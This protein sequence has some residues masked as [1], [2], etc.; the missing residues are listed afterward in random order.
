VHGIWDSARRIAP[1][2]RG[3]TARGF[4]HVKAMD[5]TPP[6]GN[7]RLEA[8]AEQVQR[9]VAEVRRESGHEQVDLV[10][11]SMGGLVSR[12]YLGLLGGAAHVRTFVSISAPHQGTLVAYCAPLEGVR[13]MR[14]GS[15]LLTQLD[16][17]PL[18]EVAVHC[19][20]TPFDAT[21]VPGSSGVL[22]GAKSVHRVPVAWHRWMLSDARVHDLVARLLRE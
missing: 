3:L 5:L 14:P 20:Y 4:Q 7:A 8:L 21:I 22:R 9:Y 16:S 19:I 6:W 1:L 15:A 12:A 18:G 10:G 11:F 13:Q 17:T 2:T